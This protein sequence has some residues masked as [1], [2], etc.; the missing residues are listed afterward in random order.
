MARRAPGGVPRPRAEREQTTEEAEVF[1]RR[2]AMC[3]LEQ[4]E[5]D[6][7]P[8]RVSGAGWVVVCVIVLG[9]LVYAIGSSAPLWGHR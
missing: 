1:S 7:P 5:P 9:A 6:D 8:R 4:A 3:L 2:Q